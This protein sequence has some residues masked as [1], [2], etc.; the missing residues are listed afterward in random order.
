MGQR[1]RG[2]S[3]QEGRTDATEVGVGE[4]N[5]RGCR[6]GSSLGYMYVNSEELGGK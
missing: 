6:Y 2:L 3:K 1:T 4:L 5:R